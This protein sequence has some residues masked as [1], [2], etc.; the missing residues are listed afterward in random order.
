MIIKFFNN[1]N[2]RNIA[3]L[4]KYKSW[5]KNKYQLIEYLN[6]YNNIYYL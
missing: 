1:Y 2:L 5:P 3:E 6:K 4:K